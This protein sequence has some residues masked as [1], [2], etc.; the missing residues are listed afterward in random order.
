MP[1]VDIDQDVARSN[2]AERCANQSDNENEHEGLSKGYKRGNFLF[3]K[4]QSVASTSATS[5]SSSDLQKL[6][7]FQNLSS[8]LFKFNSI[9]KEEEIAEKL[10]ESSSYNEILSSSWATLLS[11]NP[12]Y[13]SKMTQVLKEA[14]SARSEPSLSSCLPIPQ[15]LLP[16]GEMV[17][18]QLQNHFRK[19][20][21]LATAVK[22]FNQPGPMHSVDEEAED[23]VTS[24]VTGAKLFTIKTQLS[25]FFICCY[26]TVLKKLLADITYYSNRVV[27]KG[28]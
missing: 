10:P 27:A 3:N 16:S 19:L 18:Q 11:S 20:Q 13:T 24:F 17:L 12:L 2:D 14:Q 15:L 5:T 28:P 21:R 26:I 7:T 4:K 25:S 6:F 22:E 9:Q 8:S 23:Q 1:R